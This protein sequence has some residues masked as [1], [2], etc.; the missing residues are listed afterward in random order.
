MTRRTPF[1]CLEAELNRR[2]HLEAKKRPGWG[3]QAAWVFTGLLAGIGV[4][5]AWIVIVAL[6]PVI[7]AAR[8]M[9]RAGK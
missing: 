5:L 1:P 3:M 9:R 8:K 7:W 4:G 6:L 2:M